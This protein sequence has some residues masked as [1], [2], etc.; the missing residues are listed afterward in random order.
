MQPTAAAS[1]DTRYNKVSPVRLPGSSWLAFPRG[2]S[3][4]Y[5]LIEPLHV[6]TERQEIQRRNIVKK[7]FDYSV[8][9]NHWRIL[10]LRTLNDLPN[11]FKQMIMDEYYSMHQFAP[12]R[13][14][15]IVQVPDYYGDEFEEYTRLYSN[16]ISNIVFTHLEHLTNIPELYAFFQ[17]NYNSARN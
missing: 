8:R 6:S 9:Y 1:Y 2:T 7:I 16:E 17:V 5:Y 4:H 13:V 12:Y 15:G 3:F 10:Y 14:F 11:N